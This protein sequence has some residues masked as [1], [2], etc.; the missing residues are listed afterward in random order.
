VGPGGG[1]WLGESRIPEARIV[2]A[3][4]LVAELKVQAG[5]SADPLTS[6]TQN[7]FR[8]D[9]VILFHLSCLSLRHNRPYQSSPF[10]FYKTM[11]RALNFVSGGSHKFK[12]IQMNTYYFW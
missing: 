2:I 12:G 1:L 9:C 5:K 10:S 3:L 8:L 4:H 7:N 11:F 6:M